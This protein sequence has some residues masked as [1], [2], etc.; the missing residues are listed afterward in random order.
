MTIEE[1][2]VRLHNLI[3]KKWPTVK[4]FSKRYNIAYS[5]LEGYVNGKHEPSLGKLIEIRE[6]LGCTWDELLG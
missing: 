4:D 3:T 1:F 5:S 2:G 6:G